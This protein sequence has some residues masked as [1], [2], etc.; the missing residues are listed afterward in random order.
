MS[1]K[2]V[3]SLTHYCCWSSISAF[4]PETI[5]SDLEPLV[6]SKV[7][8]IQIV[9]IVPVIASENIKLIIID[10]CA[11]RMPRTWPSFRIGYVLKRPFALV[12]TVL[13]KVIHSI[14]PVVPTKNV[15]ESL[16][17]YCSVSVPCRR[18][19]II[20]REYFCP[21]IILKVEFEKVIS[22]IC[23]IIPTKDVKVVVQCDGRV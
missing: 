22:A 4:G 1:T 15:D 9:S 3:H 20:N 5:P 10:D 8:S 14:K 18:R 13:M 2:Q 12:N 17:D 7:K 19:W 21:L 6:W 11:V 23:A 16:V